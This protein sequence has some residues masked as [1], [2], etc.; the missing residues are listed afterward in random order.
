MRSRG[1]LLPHANLPSC[2][3]EFPDLA[4]VAQIWSSPARFLASASWSLDATSRWVD[5]R[6]SRWIARPKAT[7]VLRGFRLFSLL[8]CCIVVFSVVFVV[9]VVFA[10]VVIF[11]V[12]VVFVVVI[13]FAVV[14]LNNS[15]ATEAGVTFV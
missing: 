5:R 12:V 8:C 4:A 2:T 6:V 14:D 7:L 1:S 13:V 15:C 9:V 11:A 3:L 10:V